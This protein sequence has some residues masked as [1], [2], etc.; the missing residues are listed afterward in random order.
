MLDTIEEVQS[1]L[2]GQRYL[3]DRSVSTV[4][5]LAL[6][7]I[8]AKFAWKPILS[9]LK[10]REESI[11]QALDA[12]EKATI[13]AAIKDDSS[14]VSASAF[15]AAVNYARANDRE[16]SLKYCDLAD[17]DPNRKAQVAELRALLIK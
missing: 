2:A 11:Q 14:Q 17:R 1:A 8:M 9:S 10:E 13:E 6:F 12:A 7:F 5:F 15:N 16:K 4:V 3:A